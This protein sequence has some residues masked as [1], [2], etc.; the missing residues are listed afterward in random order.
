M[1][2]REWT[3]PFESRL[4]VTFGVASLC[5][6]GELVTSEVIGTFRE[7]SVVD[8][9]SFSDGTHTGTNE[10][11]LELLQCSVADFALRAGNVDTGAC[12]AP[13]D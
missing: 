7:P 6:D 9:A 12:G 5:F 4:E 1:L 10:S 2:D 8:I 11:E 13:F 3:T